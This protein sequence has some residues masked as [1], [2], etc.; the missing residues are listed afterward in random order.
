[1]HT[2]A[3]TSP[4]TSGAPAA[5]GFDPGLILMAFA[6]IFVLTIAWEAWY[7]SKRDRSIYS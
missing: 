1:M 6:P 3:M 7:W 5:Q 4:M 2:C